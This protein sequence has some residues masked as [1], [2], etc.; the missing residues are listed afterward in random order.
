MGRRQGGRN[1]YKLIREGRIEGII[2][3]GKR[4]STTG[5]RGEAMEAG[6]TTSRGENS[7]LY[8]DLERSLSF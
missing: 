6:V 4:G 8:R 1:V 5:E 3:K 7:Q 2:N